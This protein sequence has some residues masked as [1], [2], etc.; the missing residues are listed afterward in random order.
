MTDFVTDENGDTCEAQST[1]VSASDSSHS[2]TS[3]DARLFA[4]ISDQRLAELMGSWFELPEAI[5]AGIHA[6]VCA[7]L[8]SR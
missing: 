2:Q 3:L 5:R 4:G 8:S 1:D 7:T 6:M